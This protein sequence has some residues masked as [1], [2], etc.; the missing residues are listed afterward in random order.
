MKLKQARK[1]Q[2]IPEDRMKDIFI[3]GGKEILSINSI[4]NVISNPQ[5]NNNQ[6]DQMDESI[7]FSNLESSINNPSYFNDINSNRDFQ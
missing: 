5:L 4:S 1:T 6:I 7:N 2:I 3:K